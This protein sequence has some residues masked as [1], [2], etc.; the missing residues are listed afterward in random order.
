MLNVTKIKY[1][2]AGFFLLW[3]FGAGVSGC[4]GD[5]ADEKDGIVI[6]TIFH[7][8][9]DESAALRLKAVELAVDEINEAA[10]FSREVRVVNLSPASGNSVDDMVAAQNT[11]ELKETYNAIGVISLYSNLAE[12]I[13]SVTNSTG[14]ED[15][16]QCN[17]SASN[18]LLNDTSVATADKNDTFYRTVVTDVV[19]GELMV[20][21]ITEE[22]EWHSVG[23]Y[24][25]DNTF[26][27]GLRDLLVAMFD[28]VD[29][30]EITFDDVHPDMDFS[31]GANQEELDEI[32]SLNLSGA[33]DVVILATHKSQSP[34]IVEYLIENGFEGGLLLSDGAKTEDIFITDA[35]VGV[36]LD[37]TNIMIGV[38]P[39][40]MAGV[41]SSAFSQAFEAA[42]GTAPETY[43]S[44]AYDCTFAIALSALYGEDDVVAQSVKDNII[45][46]KESNRL[47]D[48]V[49]VGIGSEGFSSA[50][51]VIASGGFVDLEGASGRLLFDNNGD[52]PEQ[53][54]RTF[55]PNSG[56][57]G[58]EVVNTYDSNLEITD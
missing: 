25:V 19:Q 15:L 20:K 3:A 39:D 37:D 1:L 44:T 36:W 8:D 54:M 16:V 5:S 14:Y 12:A 18:V 11:K 56:A 40:T 45:N 48:E 24:S 26:G 27:S 23:V 49:T 29:G 50:A 47:D 21:L 53:G 9:V 57:T 6:G 33:L 13:I 41:N 46:F 4:N 31:V 51:N 34:L 52:R 55:G 7:A 28:E 2:L 30:Y 42:Y 22:Y 43:S 35:D 32:I 38:E 58:F 10:V 17:C